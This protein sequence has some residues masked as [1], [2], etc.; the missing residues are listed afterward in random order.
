[1]E[2]AL[3]SSLFDAA[4]RRH[5]G[6]GA[7]VDVRSGWLTDAE[8]LFDELMEQIPWRAERRQ[9]YERVLDVPRLVSFHNLVDGASPAPAAETD[10]PPAQ[11]HIRG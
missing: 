1:M 7:W 3:Q 8:S 4:D 5:L 2:L 9:M 6:D 10:A 11:R